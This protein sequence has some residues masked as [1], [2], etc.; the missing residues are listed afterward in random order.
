MTTTAPATKTIQVNVNNKVQFVLTDFGNECW[1][2]LAQAEMAEFKS[3]T[4]RPKEKATT[5][6]DDPTLEMQFWDFANFFGPK[7]FVGSPNLFVDNEVT[8][9]GN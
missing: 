2:K 8:I 6:P 7:L 3:S 1:D 4:P 5:D 9:E